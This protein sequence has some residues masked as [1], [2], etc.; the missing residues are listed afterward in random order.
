LRLILTVIIFI[1]V[2][3]VL[4]AGSNGYMFNWQAKTFELTGQISLSI[5]QTPVTV[6]MNGHAVKVD[7]SPVQYTDLFPGY[8]TLSVSKSGYYTWSAT[9]NVVAGQVD[10]Y[11]FVTLF[12]ANPSV[13]PATADE[14]ADL[15]SDSQNPS[16]STQIETRGDELWVKPIISNYPLLTFDNQFELIAR[17]SQPILKA[18]IYPDRAHIGL[19]LGNEIHIIDYDGSNDT[20]VATLSS[21]SP[22]NFMFTDGGKTL[23]YQDGTAIYHR[24]LL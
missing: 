18:V 22:T 23:V 15:V 4:I 16:T 3:V 10:S 19:Q 7:D 20:V 1:G 6:T 2:V 12:L 11:P 21:D 17:Y 24:P 13:K 8:D 9:P 14:Q 5:N